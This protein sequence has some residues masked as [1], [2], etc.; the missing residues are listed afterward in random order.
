M[1]SGITPSSFPRSGASKKPRAIHHP[2]QTKLGAVRKDLRMQAG[3][4][5]NATLA[6][7]ERPEY[8]DFTTVGGGSMAEA[9]LVI[10]SDEDG[11][12]TV[13][14]AVQKAGGSAGLVTQPRHLGGDV[15]DW[16]GVLTVTIPT[17][18]PLLL[19]IEQLLSRKRIK[20]LEID[21]NK[22]DNLTLDEV[23]RLLRQHL[24]E[25]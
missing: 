19:A 24:Q 7:E 1:S 22:V 23:E 25:K 3:N 20:E 12:N 4:Q 14:H 18:P 17:L 5:R 2:V 9:M 16:I 10:K 21:G 6:I 15:A 8:R 13:N 11:V